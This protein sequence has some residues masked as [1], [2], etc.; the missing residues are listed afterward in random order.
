MSAANSSAPS[1]RERRDRLRLFRSENVGPI[2]FFQLL[3]RFG[4]A[5]EALDALPDLARR[6][7]RRSPITICT[8]SSAER[9]IEALERLGARLVVWGD[10][11]YPEAL[12]AVPDAPPALAVRGRADLLGCRSIAI[13]GARN[14]SANGRRFARRLAAELS[15]HGLVVVSGMARGIDAGAHEGAVET[16]TIAVMG[17]GVDIIYPKENAALYDAIVERGAVIAEQPLGTVPQA[18]HFPH[19]NR[20]ISG[21]A[22]GT[23][24]VEAAPRSGSLITARLALDQGREVFAVPGSPLDPRARGTNDLIRQGAVLTESAEDVLRVIGSLHGACLAEPRAED[25]IYQAPAPAAQDD[26]AVARDA[27]REKLGPAPVAVDE[28]VRQCGL[29]AATVATALLEL[30]LAGQ[31][32]RHPGNMVSAVSRP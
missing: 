27:V 24:V 7:G 20:I 30:E 2:S 11:A 5:T 8:T 14:A 16:A 23:V 26:L 12:A 29:T 15:Q 31:L 21:L 25:M 32:E 9:E 10:T 3:A 13:V 22:L 19:R 6:G 28:I 17:G 1:N 4:S 18:R